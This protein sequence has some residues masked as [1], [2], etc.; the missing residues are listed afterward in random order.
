MQRQPNTV[1]AGVVAEPPN[2]EAKEE[3]GT[4]RGGAILQRI[5]RIVNHTST[6]YQLKHQQTTG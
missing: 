2:N 5:P 6:Y 3:K 4:K 1:A